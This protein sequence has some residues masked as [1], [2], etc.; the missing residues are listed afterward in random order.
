MAYPLNT[1]EIKDTWL[2][3]DPLLT[4]FSI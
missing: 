1:W 3:K 2:E 4:C